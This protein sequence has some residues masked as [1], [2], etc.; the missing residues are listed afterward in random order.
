MKRLFALL[1]LLGL[2]VPSSALAV[3]GFRLDGTI[4]ES[5]LPL[6]GGTVT[7]A[8]CWYGTSQSI[9]ID[10]TTDGQLIT[11][12]SGGSNN[13][14]LIWDYETTAN[15]VAVS[16]GTGVTLVDY[17]A[18]QLACGSFDVSDGNVTNVGDINVDSVTPDGSSWYASDVEYL[19]SADA[20][21]ADAG[22]VR[23]GSTECVASEIATPGT[24]ITICSSYDAA[25]GDAWTVSAPLT[26]G[27]GAQWKAGDD[28]DSVCLQE[29]G[30]SGDQVCFT[31]SG[32]VLQVYEGNGTTYTKIS[33]GNRL[34]YQAATNTEL[35]MMRGDSAPGDGTTLHE[36]M[37]RGKDDGGT[38][39]E[40]ANILALSAKDDAG[41]EEGAIVFQVTDGGAD[42][43]EYMRFDASDSKVE[44]SSSADIVD[45]VEA[46]GAT[47]TQGGA[48]EDLTTDGG[49]GPFVTSGLIPDGA[50][51]I[52]ITTRVTTALATCTDFSVGDGSDADTYGVAGAVTQGT[53]TDNSDAT[54]VWTNP[55]TAASEVTITTTGTCDS[56]G[57]IRVVAHYFT[58]GAPTSN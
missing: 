57:V 46:K 7:G 13:E 2:M 3:Q 45:V 54:A 26:I 9:C 35:D 49:A 27:A 58:V 8:I 20:D 21:P 14:N 34:L 25:T 39:H 33:G 15:T 16:T 48:Y 53:T 37:F 4:Q 5:G 23:I 52:G 42:G 12:G 40:Y 18:L 43:T 17:G 28:D 10:S 56:G 44:V 6:A 41:A 30:V 1:V 50:F 55:K 22:A 38:N 51:L 36:I 32:D 29:V 19:E 24:D 47:T 31:V 11:Y